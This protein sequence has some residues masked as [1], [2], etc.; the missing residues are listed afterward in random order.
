MKTFYLSSPST[1]RKLVHT[2]KVQPRVA[3]PEC[4]HQRLRADRDKVSL[5]SKVIGPSAFP[6]A[7][8]GGGRGR[9]DDSKSRAVRTSILRLAVQMII[10]KNENHL[11][12]TRRRRR[13]GGFNY[14]V[15]NCGR[16]EIW[17]WWTEEF[18]LDFWRSLQTSMLCLYN[19]HVKKFSR[20]LVR[21]YAS[22]F[23]G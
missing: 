7:E 14:H 2:Q 21:Q 20:D 5:A 6:T 12:K 10:V 15:R 22:C 4:S 8:E 17:R 19:K 23:R 13:A 3:I 18:W 9:S 1:S 11:P 16:L